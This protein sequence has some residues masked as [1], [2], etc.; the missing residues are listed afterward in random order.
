M[1]LQD[2]PG[3]EVA[4]LTSIGARLD[5]DELYDLAEKLAG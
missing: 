5:V 1:D 4:R 2:L 3:G